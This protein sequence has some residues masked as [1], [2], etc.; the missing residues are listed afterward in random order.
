MSIYTVN[1]D[2][3]QASRAYDALFI[4]TQ[5]D[6]DKSPKWWIYQCVDMARHWSRFI[7]REFTTYW[8]ALQFA[9]KWLGSM[10]SQ[11]IENTKSFVPPE[12][13]IVIFKWTKT[14][15]YG[16]IAKVWKGSNRVN[17]VIT[18]QN[19]GTWNWDWLWNNAIR[20]RT[21]FFYKDVECFFLPK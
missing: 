18:E 4:W 16:H 19:W 3:T 6:L 5:I 9:T 11:R 14:N 7:W 17:L 15:E 8:Y 2:L 13:A 10:W 12:W 1:L 20:Q 21:V